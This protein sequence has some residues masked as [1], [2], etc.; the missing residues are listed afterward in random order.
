MTDRMPSR[1]PLEEQA[2]S[3]E[4]DVPAMTPLRAAIGYGSGRRF[5]QDVAEVRPLVDEPRGIV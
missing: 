5:D 2:Q 3:F 4:S 1:R